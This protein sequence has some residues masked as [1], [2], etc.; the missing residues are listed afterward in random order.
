MDRDPSANIIDSE[1]DATPSTGESDTGEHGAERARKARDKGE[2]KDRGTVPSW[3][4][5]ALNPD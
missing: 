3:P 5:R 4:E 1:D 2:D